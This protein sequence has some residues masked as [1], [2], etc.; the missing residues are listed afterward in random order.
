MKP[1]QLKEIR[2]KEVAIEC[3]CP[4]CGCT[5]KKKVFWTGRGKPKIFCGKDRR[6]C[7][8]PPKLNKYFDAP[9]EWHNCIV[10]WEEVYG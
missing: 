4:T 6:A 10:D 1:K 2:T 5:H 7:A 8:N 9:Q 3:V